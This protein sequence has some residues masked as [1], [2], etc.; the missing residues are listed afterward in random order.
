MKKEKKE[1]IKQI[2]CIHFKKEADPKLILAGF[3]S[4]DLIGAELNLCADCE[5][6][7]AKGIIQQAH[8]ERSATKFLMKKG[9]KI[10]KKHLKN[11]DEKLSPKFDKDRIEPY[12]NIKKK[13]GRNIK[14]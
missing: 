12:M 5:L 6:K 7:L 11:I 10:A 2:Y 1:E 13:G 3:Y 8:N 14:W 9:W 4:Y